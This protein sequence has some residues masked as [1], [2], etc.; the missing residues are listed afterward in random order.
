MWLPLMTNRPAVLDRIEDFKKTLDHGALIYLRLRM[1]MPFWGVPFDGRKK[2]KEMEIHK[3]GGV[4][5]ARIFSWMP[6][7]EDVI[8]ALWNCWVRNV[9]ANLRINEENRED[10]HG[11]L[12]ITFKMKDRTHAK[13]ESIVTTD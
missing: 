10:I 6:D 4:E 3:K 5:S 7:R 13:T 9:F 2:R 8:L 12:Q 1:R 11:I